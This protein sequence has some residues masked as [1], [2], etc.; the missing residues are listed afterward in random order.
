MKGQWNY[1]KGRIRHVRKRSKLKPKK[2]NSTINRL[3][4]PRGKINFL[5]LLLVVYRL[6][7]NLKVCFQPSVTVS[8]KKRGILILSSL[9]HMLKRNKSTL[10]KTARHWWNR[11]FWLPTEE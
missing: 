4:M 5:K 9:E 7:R 8:H 10:S 6:N 3:S 11:I 1:S 2:R